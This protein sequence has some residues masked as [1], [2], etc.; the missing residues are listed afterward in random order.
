MKRWVAAVVAVLFLTTATLHILSHSDLTE[1]SCVVCHMQEA[2]LP[3]APAPA[4]VAVEAPSVEIAEAPLPRA[5][6]VRP[7]PGTAR[8]PPAVP[9]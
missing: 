3:A 6:A 4:V 1:R 5:A 2:S 8:A 9:A 7:V